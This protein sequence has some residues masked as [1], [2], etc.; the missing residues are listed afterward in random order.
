MASTVLLVRVAVLLLIYQTEFCFHSNDSQ[1]HG[2]NVKLEQQ[3][4]QISM[5]NVVDMAGKLTD[6]SRI[7]PGIEVALV[8]AD[9]ILSNLAQL[10]H[11]YVDS[12]TSDCVRDYMGAIAADIY[13]AGKVSVF[14]GPACSY[15]VDVLCPMSDR[16]NVPIVTGAGTA[17]SLSNKKSCSTLTRLSFE[18]DAIATV[19]FSVLC[20][21]G[22]ET[23]AILYS[24]KQELPMLVESIIKK[25]NSKG[26]FPVFSS[27][28]SASDFNSVIREIA[29]RA[30]G[31]N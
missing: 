4:Y 21:F 1:E 19:L 24:G 9:T 5:I 2:F 16:W 30:R 18:T 11:Q 12:G 28:V 13:C 20:H 3:R 10:F 6:I 25:L 23:V 15:M 29:L 22:W 17:G 26:I 7:G 14:I 8:K 31:K 27:S